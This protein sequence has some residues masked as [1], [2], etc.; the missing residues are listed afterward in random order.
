MKIAIFNTDAARGGAARSALR[1]H[2]ALLA[3]N[4]ETTML[5]RRE[6]NSEP[7]VLECGSEPSSEDVAFSLV[8]DCFV[9][10][11]RTTATNTIFSLGLPGMSCLANPA[12]SD[13]DVFNLHWVTNF[14]A[15]SQI[16]ELLTLGKPVVWTLHDQWPMTGGC[17]YPAGCRQ[18]T[19]LC[20]DC[21]Q[22]TEDPFGMVE[23][24][25]QQ[26]L[27]AYADRI[28][29]VAPSKWMANEARQSRVFRNSRIEAIPNGLDLKSFAPMSRSL[30]R[31]P[32]G[33]PEDAFVMLFACSSAA[34]SRKGG[35]FLKEIADA[36]GRVP[37]LKSMHRSGKLRLLLF[38]WGTGDVSTG[39]LPEKHMGFLSG[40]SDLASVYSAADVLLHLASE[41]NL[42]NTVLEAM[43]CGTPVLAFDAGGARE[44]VIDGETGRLVPLR[45]LDAC[46]SALRDMIDNRDY[47]AAL[48]NRSRKRM[49]EHFNADIEARR[50]LRL[51]EELIQASTARPAA[52]SALN[53]QSLDRPPERLLDLIARYVAPPLTQKQ[54]WDAEKQWLEDQK[55]ALETE[56]QL[57]RTQLSQAQRNIAYK[58]ARSLKKTLE[59]A[60]NFLKNRFKGN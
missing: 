9:N 13:A 45:N 55:Q 60:K 53:G 42:P 26:R 28:T 31:A 59:G 36:L 14:L 48:G 47:C 8:Q 6:S 46:V 19:S 1:L 15:P 5:V 52:T 21:P 17:H 33:I 32:L 25:F 51:F 2:R 37:E 57:L 38:G 44:M 30:A 43:A 39:I 23:M 49:E 35:D 54:R 27:G 22:L 58:I 18:F 11:H 34:E 7:G 41:D 3:V 10:A 56:R 12:V 50:Y 40:D 24:L 16:A 29:I 20:R 4:P